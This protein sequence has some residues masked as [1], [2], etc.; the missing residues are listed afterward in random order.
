MC[1][2]LETVVDSLGY[3]SDAASS[4]QLEVC[5]A[6]QCL[7]PCSLVIKNITSSNNLYMEF[8]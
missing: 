5:E 4:H 7:V 6:V 8:V 3:D 2:G 1:V